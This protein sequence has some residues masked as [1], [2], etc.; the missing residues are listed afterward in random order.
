MRREDMERLAFLYLCGE[1]DRNILQTEENINL[2]DFLKLEYWTRVLDFWEY[3]K[4]LWN[5]FGKGLELELRNLG[6]R[7]DEGQA[8]RKAKE[9]AELEQMEKWNKELLEC[10]KKADIEHL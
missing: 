4:Y 7:S 2:S 1:K 9:K 5:K 8:E 6:I 10:L 3:N